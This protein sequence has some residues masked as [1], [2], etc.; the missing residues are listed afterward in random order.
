[1]KVFIGGS[2]TVTS[3]NDE[4]RKVID[5]FCEQNAEILIGDCFGADKLVQRYLH[6][7]GYR[8]VTVYVSG[9]KVRN[10]VGGFRTVFVDVPDGS[11]GYGFDAEKDKQMVLTAD[12]GLM[13][14][15][16]KSRG[17]RNNIMWLKS[18]N[19]PCLIYP[20]KA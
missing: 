16:G 19:K 15:N 20:T 17:T 11:K 13:I 7:K 4:I 1:M 14:W 6:E 2:K 18:M 3:L 10:N 12:T 8:N 5:T 9:S